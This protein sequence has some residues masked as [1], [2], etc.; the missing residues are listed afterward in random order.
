[1]QEENLITQAAN[2]SIYGTFEG[3]SLA[4]FQL[5]LGMLRPDDALFHWM[6]SMCLVMGVE[7]VR[8]HATQYAER[9]FPAV[10]SDKISFEDRFSLVQEAF[11]SLGWGTIEL[12]YYD[13]KLPQ[14]QFLIKESV[15][16]T[17]QRN[18]PV[19]QRWGFPMMTGRLMGLCRSVWGGTQQ[20]VTFQNHIL[21]I[22]PEQSLFTNWSAEQL[23]E[24]MTLL[25]QQNQN[26]LETSIRAERVNQAKSVF[27]AN[28]SHEI[29]TP[30]NGVIGMTNL[31][32][33]TQLNEEQREYVEIIRTSSEGLLGIINDILDFS[34]IEAG[35]IDIENHPLDIED[36]VGEGLDIVATRAHSK[37][38][39]VAS[40]I[41]PSLPALVEGDSTRI[42]Q[43][44]V[45]LL[46]N[47]VKF[48]EEGEI[49]V[50]AWS[51]SV[52]HEQAD[53]YIS[54]KD[55]GIGIPAEK[56]SNL[57]EAFT[58]AEAST[59]RKFGGTGLGLS[60]S[61]QLC[62]MMGGDLWVE[63]APGKGSTFTFR[64]KVSILKSAE[65]RYKEQD[66]DHLKG[67]KVLIVDD[68]ATNRQILHVQLTHWGMVPLAVEGGKKALSLLREE[69]VDL[70]L[71]DYHMPHMNGVELA[72][73]IHQIHSDLSCI[74]LS[75]LGIKVKSSEIVVALNKPVKFRQLRHTMLYV[76]GAGEKPQ[77]STSPTTAPVK[78]D[79]S[80]VKILLAEDN[81]VNQKVALRTLK[82]FGI[83]AEVAVN[84][85]EAVEKLTDTTFDLVLM[86]MQMPVMDGLEATRKI[87]SLPGKS[88]TP[89]IAMTASAMDSDRE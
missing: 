34:K 72:H 16:I 76:L 5:P 86:D 6:K 84:G 33:Q 31:L 80:H 87:R 47:A 85:K 43:V 61:K 83:E 40:W 30:M 29:R 23:L 44:L 59:T 55:T 15:E 36:I 53:I 48:T 38:L 74:M 77:A 19:E 51:L 14:A 3:D 81:A 1:M 26:L 10:W 75:S 65:E 52:D 8:K 21:T 66:M 32:S 50:R 18:I 11:K 57:F 49:V 58:Q 39:E 54:V 70:V 9:G 67:K 25:E 12:A 69:N 89:I 45:N 78:E 27:L 42:R 7:E 68:N 64:V 56:Q 22:S 4:I 60:I 71:L 24:E 79:F 62:H 46:S 73:Q 41:D 88:E 28:M 82:K 20:S 35:K 2:L 13:A 17:Y 63:S 37:G